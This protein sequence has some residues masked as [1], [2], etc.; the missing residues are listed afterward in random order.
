MTLS[1]RLRNLEKAANPGGQMIVVEQ[2][3]DKSNGRH[4]GVG[5]EL[6]RQ[7]V[8]LLLTHGRHRRRHGQARQTGL[9]GLARTLPPSTR[10]GRRRAVHT[11]NPGRR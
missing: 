3:K 10:G 4:P 2:H 6:V 11:T 8:G 7:R 1:S 5:H 9:T